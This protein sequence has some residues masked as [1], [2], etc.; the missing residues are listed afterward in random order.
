MNTRVLT[1]RK[2]KLALVMAHQ[3]LHQLDEG[4]RHAVIG[5]AG[6]LVAFRSGAEDAAILSK[7]F[8]GVLTSDDLIALP[9]Y[10]IAVRLMVDG[11]PSRPF[12]A[13]TIRPAELAD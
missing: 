13:R 1:L 7:E 11:E 6:T 9:N 8:M 12:S 3:H 2:Y 5:N 10:E 4:V